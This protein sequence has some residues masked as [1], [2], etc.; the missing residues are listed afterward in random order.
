MPPISATAT[1][2][3]TGLS[4][5][6]SRSETTLPVYGCRGR[7]NAMSLRLILVTSP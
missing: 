4:L 6:S 7:R 5:G 3:S 1:A 2:A